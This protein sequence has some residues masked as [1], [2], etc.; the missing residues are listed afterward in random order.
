MGWLHGIVSHAA[1]DTL[2]RRRIMRLTDV[3]MVRQPRAG[4]D[5][6]YGVGDPAGASADRQLVEA[7]LAR[8]RPQARAALV[9]RHYY[10]YDYARIAELLDTSP[11]NVGALLSRSHALLR[12]RLADLRPA[13]SVTDRT[14]AAR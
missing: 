5:D 11:G 7:E 12:E 9:L 4:G 10:G 3:V 8:L 13:R 6:L 14:E 1:L 2:R